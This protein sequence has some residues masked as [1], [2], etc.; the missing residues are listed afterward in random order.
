MTQQQLAAEVGVHQ[1][2]VSHWERGSRLPNAEQLQALAELFGANVETLMAEFFV[3]ND[4]ERALISDAM[5]HEDDKTALL[6]LYRTA[7]RR[8]SEG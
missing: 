8:S 2:R 3:D 4:V 1:T 6:T 5:L 7:A